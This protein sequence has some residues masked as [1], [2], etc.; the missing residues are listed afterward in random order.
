MLRTHG[1]IEHGSQ[2]FLNPLCYEKGKRSSLTS[3]ATLH[4]LS[5]EQ[6]DQVDIRADNMFFNRR[7]SM[8]HCWSWGSQTQNSYCNRPTVE[9]G[10]VPLVDWTRQ[11]N[12]L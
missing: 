11:A 3:Q 8:Q 1:R 6:K 2:T 9:A 10:D 7:K 5:F 4:G 12:I